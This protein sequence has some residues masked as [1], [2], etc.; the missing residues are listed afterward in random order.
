MREGARRIRC[1]CVMDRYHAAMLFAA[2]VC[3]LLAALIYLP[4]LAYEWIFLGKNRHG[5]RER[6]GGVRE[7]GPR[8][9]RIWIHAVSVGEMNATRTL[10]TGLRRE[11]ADCEIILSTTT[12]TGYAQGRSLYPDLYV[13]RFPLDFSWVVRRALRRLRPELIVLVEL[14]LWHN[15]LELAGRADIPVVVFNGRLSARSVRRFGWVRRIV[16][17]M[18]AR[19]AW[20][21]AQDETYAGRFVALGAPR[22]RVGVTGSVK[23][24]TA[25][26]ER[27]IPGAEELAR[28]MGLCGEEPLWVC[29]STGPGEEEIILRAY[30]EVRGRHGRLRLA[31]IPRKPE[32]FDEVAQLIAGAGYGCVRRSQRPDGSVAAAPG[33]GA[34]DAPV[35]LGDTMG[36]LRKFYCLASVVFVGRSLVPMGGS[37]V[38]EAAALDK[39]LLV[40][41]HTENFAEAVALLREAGALIETNETRLAEDVLGLLE[42]GEQARLMGRAGLRVVEGQRGAT[43]KTLAALRLLL[44]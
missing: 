31:I 14:E 22:E 18:F 21:G 20:V 2:D 5:W 6:F 9:R 32:R 8:R 19:L 1:R 36:E 25:P 35:L 37:D 33:D 12:D 17:P 26:A 42:D 7:L 13:F 28:A 11:Y 10:V 16:R 38:I 34:S 39:P 15:L 41:A 4:R 29:G 30:R 43:E 24:D 27:W 40:G 44:E 3:Y 23:F